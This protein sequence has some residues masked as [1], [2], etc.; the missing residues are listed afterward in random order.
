MGT[1]SGM[2][3]FVIESVE[4]AEVYLFKVNEMS[5]GI[6]QYPQAVMLAQ[7]IYCYTD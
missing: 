1:G 4:G 5:T 3:H 2:V 6:S 7:F